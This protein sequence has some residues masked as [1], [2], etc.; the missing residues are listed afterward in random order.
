MSDLR[1]QRIVMV[2]GANSGLG[3]ATAIS[4]AKQN[5]RVVMVC[6]DPH[7]GEL[8]K[9]EIV[10][11]SGNPN[12][13]LL[14]CDFSALSNVRRLAIEY[15]NNYDRLDV[16]INNAGIITRER[17]LTQDGYEMQ[18][19]VNHLAPFLLTNLLLEQLKMSKA[20]RIVT[21]SSLGHFYG[22]IH[23][24]DLHFSKRYRFFKA[25]AQTKLANILFT[26]ELARRLEGTGV[27]ANS[28]NPG[29]AKTNISVYT[30]GGFAQFLT[31]LFTP[32][33]KTPEE[34][35][36][37]SVYL[38]MSHEVEGIT[39]KYFSKRKIVKSKSATYDRKM[40]SRLWEVSAE[41]VNLP[42]S[43]K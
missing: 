2:T 18:F 33:L 25:Y 24:S 28:L 11:E 15:S 31:T 8:A 22:K 41:M 9:E 42:S 39:G 6:R 14:I 12:I 7:R 3:K 16:L 4:L 32:F 13:D 21:V 10:K 17:Q 19:G 29:E 27:T 34:H 40:A 43:L 20:G 26:Y 23:F 38:A 35:A 30:E 1:Q 37:T 5:A 36:D